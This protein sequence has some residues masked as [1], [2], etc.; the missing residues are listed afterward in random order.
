LSEFVEYEPPEKKHCPDDVDINDIDDILSEMFL[1][2]IPPD[3]DE[4][5]FVWPVRY[6]V[7]IACNTSDESVV[8]GTE[9]LDYDEDTT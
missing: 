3:E 8:H 9:V 4:L 7:N 1:P 5:Y 6:R 2:L